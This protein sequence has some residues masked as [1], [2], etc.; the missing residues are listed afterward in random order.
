MS[1]NLHI[2]LKIN[3]LSTDAQTPRWFHK[4]HRQY[5]KLS[6]VIVTRLWKNSLNFFFSLFLPL[7]RSLFSNRRKQFCQIWYET[8]KEINVFKNQKKKN[9]FAAAFLPWKVWTTFLWSTKQTFRIEI[10]II[11]IDSLEY[12]LSQEMIFRP[13]FGAH[14]SQIKGFP[15]ERYWLEYKKGKKR[16]KKGISRY[17]LIKITLLPLQCGIYCFRCTY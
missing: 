5:W 8:A 11:S 6:W 14:S 2:S 12:C 16:R 10:S 13:T 1:D 9:N 15:S 4:R 7:P 3:R 17:L